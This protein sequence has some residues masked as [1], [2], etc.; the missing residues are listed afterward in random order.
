MT[1]DGPSVLAHWEKEFSNL[2]GRAPEGEFDDQFWHFKEKELNEM[3]EEDLSVNTDMNADISL[4][5]VKRVIDN[6]KKGKAVGVDNIPT[7]ALQNGTCIAMLHDLFNK[8]FK[9][10][11]LPSEWSKCNIVPIGKGKTSIS[12]D[13][14]SH[15]GLALQCCVYKLYCLLLNN[16][17]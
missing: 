16:R 3:M 6:A 4:M 7:E 11:L 13:P 8:C 10:G 12:T 17:L 14:L 9:T 15:R 5:E 1:R 2:Y